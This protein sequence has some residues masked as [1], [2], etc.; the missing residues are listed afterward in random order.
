MIDG[1][2]GRARAVLE[3]LRGEAGASIVER[4]LLAEIIYAQGVEYFENGNDSAAESCFSDAR[5]IDCWSLA[6]WIAHT[7]AKLNAR[8]ETVASVAA[9]GW[10]RIDEIGDRLVRSDLAAL[11][12][13]AYFAAGEFVLA[14]R[15]YDYSLAVMNLPRY[16]NVH[17]QAGKLGM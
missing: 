5:S 4:A 15:M 9:V 11:F 16:V 17:A 10:T 13:D 8:P 7:A 14:R 12:G 2:L 1:Q 6:Y 3:P